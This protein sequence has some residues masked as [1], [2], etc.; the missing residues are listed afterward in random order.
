MSEETNARVVH[1]IKQFVKAHGFA[2]TV[3]E[4]AEMLG[5]G[6]SSVQKALLELAEGGKIK[7]TNG[8]ARGIVLKEDQ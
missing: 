1:A 2:P 4:L 3:R 5:G 8:V 6:H 7:K